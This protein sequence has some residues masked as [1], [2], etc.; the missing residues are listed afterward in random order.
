[1]VEDTIM[2][3]IAS[4]LNQ[5]KE[6]REAGDPGARESI[7]AR[8]VSWRGSG[9]AIDWHEN[10]MQ[11]VPFASRPGSFTPTIDDLIS[12]WE[13]VDPGDVLAETVR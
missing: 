13:L 10:Q 6:R 7:W 11:V 9:L 12:D 2:T 3:N 4:I 5:L 1:V 8:P